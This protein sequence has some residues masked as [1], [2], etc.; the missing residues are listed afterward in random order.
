M[1]ISP[2]LQSHWTRLVRQSVNTAAQHAVVAT[3]S[4]TEPPKADVR[5]STGAPVNRPSHHSINGTSATL[6]S[7]LATNKVTA[8][9]RVNAAVMRPL[10]RSASSQQMRKP[11]PARNMAISAAM[12]AAMPRE[13]WCR[14]SYASCASAKSPT[15]SIA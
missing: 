8:S 1:M 14:S 7:T 15:T 13:A 11:R 6:H 4:A 5:S 2:R 9:R 3:P 12:P 10:R